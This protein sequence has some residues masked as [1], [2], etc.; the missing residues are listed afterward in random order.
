MQNMCML[1]IVISQR[2]PLKTLSEHEILIGSV[3][4]K[5]RLPAEIVC[6]LNNIQSITTVT[7]NSAVSWN[8]TPCSHVGEYRH[9]EGRRCFQ[10]Q[11]ESVHLHEQT[12]RKVGTQTHWIYHVDVSVCLPCTLQYSCSQAGS[13]SSTRL[14]VN[15]WRQKTN[16]TE[17]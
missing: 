13:T 6:P 8:A 15:R 5:T 14:N 16:N 10:L 17:K 4:L 3:I 2:W 11:D 9:F 1:H 12:A 7:Q